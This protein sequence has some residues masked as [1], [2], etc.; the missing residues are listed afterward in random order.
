MGES[1]DKLA[2]AVVGPASVWIKA[3][4]DLGFPIVVASILLYSHFTTMNKI[5]ATLERCNTLS[6]RME[7]VLWKVERRLG[8][9]G[10]G[11]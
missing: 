7:R 9:E 11:R 5:V 6:E 4:R 2:R 3:I 1:D 8:V 10:D